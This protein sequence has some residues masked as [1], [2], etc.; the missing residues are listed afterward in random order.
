MFALSFV[1][2]RHRSQQG[3]DSAANSAIH[4]I[5]IAR[6]RLDARTQY[7]VARRSA[8]GKTKLEAIRRLKRYIAREVFNN[9]IRRHREINR[10]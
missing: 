7:Y 10:G 5:A 8:A 6:L 4:I 9:V 1:L 3:G 2:V